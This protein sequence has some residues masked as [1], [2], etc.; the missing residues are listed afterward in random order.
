MSSPFPSLVGSVVPL[1]HLGE[2]RVGVV[3]GQTWSNALGQILRVQET[4]PVV[5]GG[6]VLIYGDALRD[7]HAAL[8]T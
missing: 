8:L 2:Q 6:V 1:P 5:T 4:G 7:V 3:L